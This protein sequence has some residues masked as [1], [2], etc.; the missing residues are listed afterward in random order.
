MSE[1]R[2]KLINK[3]EEKTMTESNQASPPN[4]PPQT[5]NVNW[6]RQMM[7]EMANRF[8][9]EQKTARRWTI[10]FRILF[11]IMGFFFLLIMLAIVSISSLSNPQMAAAMASKSGKHTAVVDLKGGIMEDGLASSE[12]LIKGLRLA[13]KS[14]NS[15]GVILLANSPGGSPVQA[16]YVYDEIKRL[17]KQY[18]K[19]KIYTVISDGCFSAC[20]YIASATD[21]IYANR[22]SLVG[23]IGVIHMSMGFKELMKKIGVE[24]RIITSGENKAFLNPFEQLKPEHVEHLKKILAK[25]HQVFIDDVKKGRA[26]KIKSDT[27]GIFSGLIWSAEK[28]KEFG[29]IDALGNPSYVAKS[30]IGAEVMVD[31]TAKPGF[32]KLLFNDAGT[33]FKQG[34]MSGQTNFRY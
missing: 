8:V 12:N 32:F 5:E 13:M 31:Y 9:S 16:A 6:E 10:A 2:K 34:V 22:Q 30:V 33:S 1:K 26:K 29:L 17:R 3:P 27:P 4:N 14:K 24:P 19:K 18:P 20:Y 25:T 15:A 11:I 21:G 7:L 23:S 28:A